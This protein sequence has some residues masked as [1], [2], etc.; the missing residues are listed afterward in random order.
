MGNQDIQNQQN[1]QNPKIQQ[2]ELINSSQNFIWYKDRSTLIALITG[3][4]STIISLINA[5]S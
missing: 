4:F 3:L 5:L 1:I 2:S